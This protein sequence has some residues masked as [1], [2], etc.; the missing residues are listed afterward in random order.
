MS[1]PVN[2]T[3]DA[4][5]GATLQTSQG[6]TSTSDALAGCDAVL[7]YFSAHWCPPCRGFTPKLV[8]AYKAY[9]AKGLKMEIVFV[10]SDRNEN[11]FD[12]YYAEMP[13]LALPY[14]ARDAKA[15]LSKKFK[16]NGIPSLVVCDG[17][18]GGLITTDGRSAVM[19][20]PEGANFPWKPP[21]LW[22]ALGDEVINQDGD[23]A[24]ISELRGAGKALGL[25]FSAHWCP[26]CKAFTPKLV[27]T[28]K[29]VKA[30][31]KELEIVFVSSDHSMADFHSYFGTMTGFHAIPQGDKRKE[32]LSKAFDVKGIPTFVMIDAET[33]AT[34]NA[35]ARGAVMADPEGANFPWA[36]PAV[37]DLGS[38][39]GINEEASLCLMADGCSKEVRDAALAVL[40]PIAEASKAAGGEM[41]FYVAHSGEGVVG[42]IRKLTKLGEAGA[43][44]QLLMIDIPSEG[45]FYV[46]EPADVTAESVNAFVDA[47][48][49]GSLQRKQL[50]T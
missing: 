39:E 13:W 47:F 46:A 27:E 28:V 15:S 4:L 11:A 18:T 43:K 31:G 29:A 45:A 3:F 34:I 23:A 37:E 35:N 24:A 40:T 2:T 32:A 48:K 7:I 33:G 22:E 8:E 12:E 17:K 38:P 26:P 25:Y 10:S 44:P 50:E 30:A 49:K 41:L 19:E 6:S 14:S 42:Q 36:P 1:T 20:D 16:V 21:T 5:F 9:K